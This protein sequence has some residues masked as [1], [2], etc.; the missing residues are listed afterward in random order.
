VI[1]FD[2]PAINKII[3]SIEK[4]NNETIFGIRFAP[5]IEGLMKG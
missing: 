5:F 2:A 1:G 3:Q 4:I